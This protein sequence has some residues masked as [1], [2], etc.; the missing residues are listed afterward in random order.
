MVR[1]SKN[2]KVFDNLNNPNSIPSYILQNRNY[3]ILEAVIVYLKERRKLSFRK[4]ASLIQRDLRYV[5]NS[6]Q[7]A[8][9]KQLVTEYRISGNFIHI[10]IE[11]IADEKLAALESVV[12][13]LKEKHSLSFSEIAKLLDRDDRT[14]WTVYK[15]AVEKYG[16]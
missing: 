1:I 7:N 5:Y 12:K 16:R 15:R 3:T 13:F 10:P 2:S 8:K 14:V 6:Y 11:V 9:E 4:I